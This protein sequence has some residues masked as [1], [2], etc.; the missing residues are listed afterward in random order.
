MHIYI[1]SRTGILILKQLAPNTPEHAN[2]SLQDHDQLGLIRVG[3]KLCSRLD[4][5]GKI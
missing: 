2:Q 4:L 5:Q 1:S 3:A